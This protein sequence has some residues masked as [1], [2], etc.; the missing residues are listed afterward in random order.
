MHS[1]WGATK[2]LQNSGDFSS[3][4][5]LPGA[6]N[7]PGRTEGLVVRVD[8]PSGA[9]PPRRTSAPTVRSNY[10]MIVSELDLME[11]LGLAHLYTGRTGQVTKGDITRVSQGEGGIR[12]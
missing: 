4:G 6:R 12:R 2:G 9:R 11:I 3:L 8:A 7:R 1:A 5:G 10:V